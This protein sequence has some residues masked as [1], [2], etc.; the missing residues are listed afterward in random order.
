MFTKIPNVLT[1]KQLI[2]LA[3]KRTQKINVPDKN[4]KYRTKKTI[5]ARTESFVDTITNKL[6]SYVKN[7]PSIDQLP[8][9]Y[10]EIIDI[11]INSNKL[12]K[13]LGAVDWAK[14]TCL[15][16]YTKQSKSLKKTG[17][18]EF[19]KQ[20][21]K[22][23]Y[24]RI[25][26]VLNQVDENLIF[27]AEAQNILKKFPNIEDI[28][29]VVIAGCPN[30][31][32]SSLLRLLS[33]AKPE[34]AT[35]PFTTKKIIVGHKKIKEKFL[36]KKYQI[37]DTP[38][39]LDRPVFERN[40]IEKQSI[41]ALTYLADVIVFIIDPSETCGYPLQNQNNMLNQIKKIFENK[42]IIVVENKM[43][44]KNTKSKNLK[45]SC[46]K[47]KGIDI[48]TQEILKSFNF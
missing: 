42:K 38:G 2:D 7:F 30:V 36:T 18:A 23:I 22:E 37:I 47:T 41:A 29:T 24:G 48:L 26:S 34:I 6:E 3:L 40:N 1:A 11:K 15:M 19:L 9:F 14:K 16:I 35:Y 20:K 17:N 12:K 33:S 13:S 43:D 39:L 10:Q 27:L 21:Q 5:I 8:K 44:L 4:A 46:E 32:K 45:I 28:P 31:G 25:S